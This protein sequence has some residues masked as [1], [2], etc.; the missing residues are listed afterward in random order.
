[1]HVKAGRKHAV[2]GQPGSFHLPLG[3]PTP[4]CS[5]MK[6]VTYEAQFENLGAGGG[7][8]EKPKKHK[9]CPVVRMD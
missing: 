4:S 1:M 7:G 2:R 3:L 8:G 5:W 6:D 9:Q